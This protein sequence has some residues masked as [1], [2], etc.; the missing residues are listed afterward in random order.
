MHPFYSLIIH[1]SYFSTC[2]K[3]RLILNITLKLK[4]RK[5]NFKGK[6]CG[7]FFRKL[8]LFILIVYDILSFLFF[9]ECVENDV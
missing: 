5:F 9:G 7:Q 1:L 8:L 6:K 4:S 3:I 2:L